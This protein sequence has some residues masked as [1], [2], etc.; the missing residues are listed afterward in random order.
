MT[1]TAMYVLVCRI[2][3]FNLSVHLGFLLE[4]DIIYYWIW[5]IF[6][7]HLF[8]V[9]KMLEYTYFLQNNDGLLR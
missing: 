5:C 9:Y 6:S 1:D 3:R 4:S 7:T 8:A 2:T